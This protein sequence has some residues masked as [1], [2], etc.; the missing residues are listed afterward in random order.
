MVIL[1]LLFILSADL[2]SRYV[3]HFTYTENH[4]AEKLTPPFTGDYILGAD[5]NGR[6]VLTRKRGPLLIRGN[7]RCHSGEVA[8]P[9]AM[10][11]LCCRPPTRSTTETP[12]C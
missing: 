7:F 12:T 8:W 6:D 5:G 1:I 10:R 4:L 11:A 3:T 2:I 9:A